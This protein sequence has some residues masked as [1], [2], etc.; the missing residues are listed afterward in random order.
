[1]WIEDLA[2]FH[3]LWQPG[4]LFSRA[5]VVVLSQVFVV[6]RLNQ[7][8][9]VSNDT[10]KKVRLGRDDVIK[11]KSANANSTSADANTSAAGAPGSALP[12]LPSIPGLG[13]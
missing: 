10:F 13:Q 11:K 4:R 9:F 5:Q 7:V 2:K 6:H 12:G 1:M 8:P 3:A